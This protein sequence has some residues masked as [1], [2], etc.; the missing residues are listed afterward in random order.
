MN[1]LQGD[2]PKVRKPLLETEAQH[3]V[4]VQ[5]TDEMLWDKPHTVAEAYLQDALRRLHE[6]V[7]QDTKER[8][9]HDSLPGH[10]CT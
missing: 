6:A 8:I 7:E 4:T 10:R 3:I 5:K 9:T 1:E 2:D